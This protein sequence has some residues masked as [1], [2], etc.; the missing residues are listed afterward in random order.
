METTSDLVLTCKACG[1]SVSDKYCSKC[2]QQLEVKR[3]TFKGLL[4]DV[5]HLFTHLDK[6][7]GYTLK[8][9]LVAPGTMQREYIEGDRARHQ[10]PFSLFFICAT[11]AGLTRYWIFLALIRIFEAGDTSEAEFFHNYMVL[12]HIVLSPL[13]ALVVYIAFSRSR[14]N[15]AEIGVLMLYTMSFFFLMASVI[16]FLK[17]VWVEFDTAYLDLPVMLIYSA[18]TFVNFFRESNKWVVLVKSVIVVIVIFFVANLGEDI[19]RELTS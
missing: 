17:F 3:I 2:G 14:F 16:T 1:A 9:L 7:I 12:V 13:Y 18:F 8:R 19:V 10:K 5:F 6:G 15:Y 11:V 4:H